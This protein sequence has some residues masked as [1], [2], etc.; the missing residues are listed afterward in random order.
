MIFP[1]VAS[2]ER[3]PDILEIYCSAVISF[4]LVL[5]RAVHRCET[6]ALEADLNMAEMVAQVLALV[7]VSRTCARMSGEMELLSHPCRN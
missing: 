7:S 5:L 1:V 4:F 6:F 2:S 3:K